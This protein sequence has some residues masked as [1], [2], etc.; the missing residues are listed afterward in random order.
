MIYEKIL[1][2]IGNT[3]LVRI[4]LNLKKFLLIFLF[5]QF[6]YTNANSQPVQTNSDTLN[7]TDRG[8][9][10]ENSISLFISRTDYQAIKATTGRKVTAKPLS[11]IINGDSVNANTVN[12]RGQT[13]LLYRRKSFSF[14]LKSKA[15]FRHG[16]K[17][18]SFKR[19]F[20]LSLSMDRNYC[21]NRLAFE[22]METLGL[23]SLFYSYCELRINGRSEG[24]YLVVER[25]EDWA[26]KKKNSPLLIRRGYDHNIDKIV[27]DKKIEK[28]EVKK[29]CYYYNQIYRCL[30]KYK[31]EALYKSLSAWLDL[32]FYMKWLAFN[33][34]V[35]NGDYT[36]EVYFYYDPGIN[37]FSIIPWDYDDLFL[38]APHEGNIENKKLLGDKFIF[39]AEDLLD[40][41]I[42]SDTYLHSVYIIQFSEVLNQLSTGVLKRV[43]ESTCAE[44]YPYYSTNEIISMSEYD[45]YKYANIE[46]LQNDMF[47]LYN[48]LRFSRDFFMENLRK[49]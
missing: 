1:Q 13:T 31:G 17:A 14:D 35:R 16:E 18:E 44:L 37:K 3:P 27:M 6:L 47:A 49:K 12:T 2:T 4:N 9:K 11:L 5:L 24:I 30:D 15:Q 21:N 36:D 48:Q 45:A 34:L 42:A 22:M 40:A 32:D 46:R 23:F 8:R 43:F 10:I 26:V 29:Y 33:Y 41:K 19:F 25:P 39:S 28:S 7:L 38:S 20:I